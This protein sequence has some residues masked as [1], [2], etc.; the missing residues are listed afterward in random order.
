M[1]T[2]NDVKTSTNAPEP[3]VLVGWSVSTQIGLLY[4][5][6]NFDAF[7]RKDFFL[8]PKID[9]IETPREV[10]NVG[11]KLD[12]V[13]SRPRTYIQREGFSEREMKTKECAY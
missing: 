4:L 5:A 11:R 13:L 3:T 8:H 9:M 7:S 10:Y 6:S 1:D 12:F 2:A